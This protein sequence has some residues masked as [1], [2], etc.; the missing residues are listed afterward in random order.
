MPVY[1]ILLF[2]IGGGSIFFLTVFF[3]YSYISKRFARRKNLSTERVD[4]IVVGYAYAKQVIPPI[5]EYIVD[6]VAYKRQLE[7]RWTVVKSAPWMS[8]KAV[9][10]TPDLLDENLVISRNSI[11][12]YTNVLEEAFP[13]GSIMTVWYNPQNPR[14]SYVE[15]FCNKDKLYKKLALLFLVLYIIFM[16]VFVTLTILSIVYNWKAN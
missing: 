2:V 4:G 3:I 15:R 10:D 9:A 13:K 7:Y 12:S 11:V 8:R 14:E 1:I 16:I 5:V 6:G